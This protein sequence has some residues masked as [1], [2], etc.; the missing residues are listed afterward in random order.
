MAQKNN[1]FGLMSLFEDLRDF[2]RGIGKVANATRNGS[3]PEFLKSTNVEPICLVENSLVSMNDFEAVLGTALDLTATMYLRV[4]SRLMTVDI[5]A[6]RVTRML[7]KLATERDVLASMAAIESE[8][9]ESLDIISAGI[10]ADRNDRKNMSLETDG[11]MYSPIIDN[12][13]LSVGK[14]IKCTVSNGREKL[15]IPVSIRLRTKTVTP[16][17][18]RDIFEANYADLNMFQRIKLVGLMEITALEA[19]TSSDIIARQERVRMADREGVIQSHFITA[20]KDAGYSAITGEIPINRASGIMVISEETGKMIERT[21]RLRLDKYSDR[22]KFFDGTAT[23]MIIIV[24]PQSYTATIYL[25]GFKDG[26]E[27]T[28]R[29]M[30]ASGKGGS[31]DLTPIIKDMLSGQVP[32]L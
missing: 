32:S 5:D 21:S 26:S 2:V 27:E 12:N 31:Q 15:D 7:E 9:K 14:L 1:G 22:E 10:E 13:K 17:L 11:K 28:F 4:F 19:I 3:L 23:M 24:D 25:R 8:Y 16:S 29:T 30:V 6:V 20:T 18:I